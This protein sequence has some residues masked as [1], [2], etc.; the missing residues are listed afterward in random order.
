MLKI[1]P[2]QQRLPFGGHQYAEYGITF[3]GETFDV[4]KDKLT[5]FRLNN[6]IPAGNPG[7]EILAH[8]AKHWPWMVKSDG[9]SPRME[10]TEYIRWRDWIFRTWRTPPKKMVTPK[11]AKE[12]W[13]KCLSCPM[14]RRRP[15]ESTDESA[16][17]VRKAFILRRGIEVPT[18][19]GFCALHGADLSVLVFTEPAK[20]FSDKKD[21][22]QPECCWV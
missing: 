2:H 8:Y 5:K 19:L 12:R 10:S 3:K 18:N 17:L 21:T 16:E 11:E 7:Q 9:E 6:N 15:M 4:V 20:D 1:A 14:L 22:V 13:E